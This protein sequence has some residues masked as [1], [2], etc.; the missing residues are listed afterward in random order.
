MRPGRQRGMLVGGSVNP[1]RGQVRTRSELESELKLKYGHSGEVVFRQ[2]ERW[3]EG[4]RPLAHEGSIKELVQRASVELVYEEFRQVLPFGTGGRRGP[5]GYGPNRLN[6]STV[7]LSVQGH[8]DFLREERIGSSE[9]KPSV[10]VANDVREFRDIRSVYKQILGTTH[11]LLGLTSRK[12]ACLAAEI[13]VANG[14]HVYMAAP[15]EDGGLLTTPELSFA[16]RE[17]G[18]VGGVNLSASH[19]HPDDNGIKVYMHTGG[20]PVPPVDETLAGYVE[21]TTEIRRSGFEDSL[22]GGGIRDV[23]VEV[24]E[25]YERMY[26]S[27]FG[28]D[29]PSLSTRPFRSP[30]VYTPLSGCGQRTVGSFLRA[31]GF[32]VTTPHSE[33]PDGTFRNIPFRTPNPEVPESATNACVFARKRGAELVLSTDPDGDRIGAVVWDSAQ[34]WIH[35]TGNQIAAIILYYL[36]LDA[37][38][39]RRRGRVVQTQVTTGLTTA[40]AKAAGERRVT[41]NLLVGFK[42]IAAVLD[43]VEGERESEGVPREVALADEFLFAAE[44]SHGVL[45]VSRLRDKDGTSGAL[46]LAGLHERLRSQG[47]T[48]FDYYC[49]IL[50]SV[51]V[52]ANR[53]RSLVLYGAD[54][55]HSIEQLMTSLRQDPPVKIAGRDVEATAD[56]WDPE[57]FGDVLSHTDR[58]ARN[59]LVYD[60]E[61]LSVA[62]RPSGTEPKL[63]FYVQIRADGREL[64]SRSGLDLYEEAERLAESYARDVYR[65]LLER[66]GIAVDEAMLSISDVVPVESKIRL[67]QRVLPELRSKME[68]GTP[69]EQLREW[70]VDACKEM[71]PGADPL[72]AI[73]PALKVA[74]RQWRKSDQT[75]LSLRYLGGLLA[76]SLDEAT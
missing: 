70:L 36:M 7:A 45:A 53:G 3:S 56:Y 14:F 41:D 64:R 21:R 17:L 2:V 33:E 42:Y 48:L 30:I 44:E 13:Y 6:E 61:E 1:R 12:L 35:L 73:R 74:V 16:I 18:A 29:F 19:N 69:A 72:P 46:Y 15:R 31:I 32:D 58:S 20:Q 34:G 67:T 49:H 52:F 62:V 71:T 4:G 28:S 75:D 50:K 22:E 60:A 11:P 59:M 39:P 63:K 24:S 25:E 66:L 37:D 55:M 65:E 9:A 47:R 8:C 5:V 10:V 27:R 26:R 68:E 23:P 51:G 40:I 54:G 76:E 57:R 38:G 43:R